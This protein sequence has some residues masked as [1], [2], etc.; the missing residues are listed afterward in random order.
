MRLFL[1]I[2]FDDKTKT[3]LYGAVQ[4]L[5]DASSAGN[6]TRMDNLHLTLVFIGE[7]KNVSAVKEAMLQVRRL[8]FALKIGKLGKFGRGGKDIYWLGVDRS[9]ALEETQKELSTALRNKGFTIEQREYRPHLTLG[10]EVVPRNNFNKDAFEKSVG[11]ITQ[12]IRT[13]DLMKSERIGG[14]LTYTKVYSVSL[15]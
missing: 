14:R 1:A 15:G 4:R 6:F 5:R 12:D 9:S 8:P 2:N 3:A 11:T 10:R 13:I 7:T